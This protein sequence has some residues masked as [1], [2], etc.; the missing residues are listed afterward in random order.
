MY[1]RA[2]GDSLGLRFMH[3]GGP[4]ADLDAAVAQYTALGAG[5][6][7]IS[8]PMELSSWD[9]ERNRV[10]R[11]V[12]R[13]AFGRLPG[14]GAVELIQPVGG[15][16]EAPHQRQLLAHPGLNHTGYWCPDVPSTAQR[17][18]ERGAT[19]ATATAPA[20]VDWR[21]GSDGVADI[22]PLLTAAHLRMPTGDL[23][24]LVSESLWPD[25]LER[26]LGPEIR[27]VFADP[28]LRTATRP[29]QEMVKPPS[30]TIVCPV[31]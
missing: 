17:L 7:A 13:I 3:F 21:P 10:V 24:E 25:T 30:T 27:Q 26:L 28:D 19:L 23:C 14:G 1:D 16:P 15:D 31:T 12:L 6:W 5:P 18:I 9:G 22:L 20:G 2:V 11:T 29:D 4:V 8:Q